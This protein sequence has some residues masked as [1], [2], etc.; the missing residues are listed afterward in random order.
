MPERISRERAET[1]VRQFRRYEEYFAERGIDRRQFLRLIAAGSAAATVLPVLVACGQVSE[2]EATEAATPAPTTP[3]AAQTPATGAAPTPAAGATPTAAAGGPQRGGTIVIGTLGEAQTIN[4]LLTN[5]SEGQW[6]ARMLFDEFLKLDLETLE[7]VPNIAKEWKVEGDTTYTFTLQDGVTFSDGTPLTADDIAFTLHAILKKE[8]ASPFVPRFI[9][10]QGAE[11]YNKG[12]ADTISG[13]EVID[14]KTIKITLKEPNAAFLANLRWLRPLPKHLLEGKSL[15]D[16]PFFQQPVGAGPFI[17][18]SWNIGG[19]F[20]AERNPH[21]WQQGLPYLDGFTHRTIADSQS[22]VIALET[23]D[24]EA[25]M[26]AQPTLADQLR[27]RENLVV[28]V[29]PPGVDINGWN[30]GEKNVEAL[31]DP[32]VRRAIAMAIDV[33]RF[34]NDFLLGLGKPAIGPVPPGHWAFKQGLQ[35]IPYDPQAAKQLIQEAGATGLRVRLT[36]NAGNKFREDWVTFTQ[37]AL[38]EIGIEGVPDLKEWTQVVQ[39]GTKGT[40]ELICPTFASMTVDPDELY[41][42]FHSSSPRNVSGYSNPEMDR[43]LEEGRRT[44]DT[45]KRKEIYGRVQELIQQDVPVFY[46]WDRPFINV[47]T[48]DFA[49]Y[50]NTVLSFFERLE[51]WYRVKS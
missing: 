2:R 17:F 48:K 12:Q 6:R 22:L 43:L 34:A 45:E 3:A 30:F 24:I 10:I 49:G 23:G 28:L 41:L 20:V 35:R 44:L 14:E 13:I 7:P 9:G 1:I 33:D 47:V 8:T 40:F 26:Y 32:R 29:R 21:Y 15:T 16:D 50:V 11:E 4:P 31:A 38:A 51:E 42:W 19:D 27:A 18:K 25:S 36:A 46:A 39:E 5:E 37:Q